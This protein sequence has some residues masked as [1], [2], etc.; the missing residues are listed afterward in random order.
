MVSG[1]WSLNPGEEYNF[2]FQMP[3]RKGD[4]DITYVIPS[5]LQMGWKNSP[6]YFCVAMQTTRELIKWML[7]LTIHTRI[8]VPH[9]H[10]KHCI[11]NP[12]LSP[13]PPWRTPKDIS[14]LSCIFEDDFYNGVAG[15][16][17]CTAKD[18]ELRWIARA[19][20]HGIH[21]VFPGP[22]TLQHHNGK[23][24][25]SE[26]KLEKGDARWK[27]SEVLLRVLVSGGPGD[28]RRVSIP[29]DKHK[30]YQA[31]ITAALEAP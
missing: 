6:A 26:R 18:E 9:K 19:N 7:V 20:L 4:P 21:G 11:P 23:D 17:L 2:A 3:K 22:G 24:S 1:K 16:V 25:I 28:Q 5:S 31:T 10:E 14:V 15:P 13:A 8:K 12:S 27:P 30:R 29:P